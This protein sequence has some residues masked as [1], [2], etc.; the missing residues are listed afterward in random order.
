M[1]LTYG[2]IGRNANARI[3]AEKFPHRRQ[4]N[5]IYFLIDRRLR[6]AGY[7]VP[8]TTNYGRPQNGNVRL[9]KQ[10]LNILQAKIK[11]DLRKIDCTKRWLWIVNNCNFNT[12]GVEP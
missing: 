4:T 12:G 6:D 11:T 5:Y 2:E 10:N 1:N 7:F 3:Y 9:G 8:T